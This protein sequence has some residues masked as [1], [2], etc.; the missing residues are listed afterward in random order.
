[1]SDLSRLRARLVRIERR[2]KAL[3]RELADERAD[4]DLFGGQLTRTQ[5]RAIKRLEAEIDAQRKLWVETWDRVRVEERR[6]LA[7][8]TGYLRFT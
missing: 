4:M 5:E 8:P 3:K 2:G 7:D 6:L 1:M